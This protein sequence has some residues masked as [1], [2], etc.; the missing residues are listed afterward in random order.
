M[1]PKPRASAKRASPWPCYRNATGDQGCHDRV[2]PSADNPGRV[3]QWQGEVIP[4]P[5]VTWPPGS[6]V[7]VDVSK[8]TDIPKYA[9]GIV[10][11]PSQA[12][13]QVED[14]SGWNK[15]GGL[16]FSGTRFTGSLDHSNRNPQLSLTAEGL[17]A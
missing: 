15:S 5:W 17:A 3:V 2:Q 6:E 10:S 7:H 12:V 11:A 16:D 1:P 4:A 8:A 9:E 14:V 13:R